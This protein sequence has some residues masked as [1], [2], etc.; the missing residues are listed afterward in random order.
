MWRSKRACSLVLLVS[1]SLHQLMECERGEVVDVVAFEGVVVNGQIKL[2]TDIRL[3]EQATVYVLIPNLKASK[4]VRIPS[5]RLVHRE[6]AADF[7]KEVIEGT[8]D[9]DL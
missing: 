8:A 5:P 1:C 7:S 3:P 9:A 6:Q 2:R 4:M